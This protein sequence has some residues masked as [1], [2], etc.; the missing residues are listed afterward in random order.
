MKYCSDSAVNSV[1]DQLH[2]KQ[3]VSSSAGGLCWVPQCCT[4]ES[5]NRLAAMYGSDSLVED[6]LVHLLTCHLKNGGFLV[7]GHQQSL[8]ALCWSADLGCAV[9]DEFHIGYEELPEGFYLLQPAFPRFAGKALLPWKARCQV[10]NAGDVLCTS[11]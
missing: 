11:N 2:A 4:G 1:E 5:N 10:D 8:E 6:I 9:I 3:T 7:L